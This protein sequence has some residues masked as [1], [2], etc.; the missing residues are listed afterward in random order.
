MTTMASPIT[1][2]NEKDEAIVRCVRQST[3]TV[4]AAPFSRPSS[5]KVPLENVTFY[6]HY[7]FML[8][9][10]SRLLFNT[11]YYYNRRYMIARFA[12]KSWIY[13]TS[14]S[15]HVNVAIKYACGVG[16]VFENLNQACVQHVAR[17]METTLMSLAQWMW[18]KS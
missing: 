18:R 8:T 7:M 9:T 5:W 17:R 6:F 13:P 11:I 12:V 4:V 10:H 14:S 1:I 16:I 3:V 2:G 15:F